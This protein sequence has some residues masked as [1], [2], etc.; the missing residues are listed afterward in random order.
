[1]YAIRSYYDE[2]A[3]DNISCIAKGEP[4]NN[5]PTSM[6]EIE[7]HQINA[8]PNPTKSKCTIEADKQIKAISLVNSCGIEVFKQKINNTS[9]QI[10]ISNTPIGFYTLFIEFEDGF[11]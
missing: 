5:T 1:M 10:D 6:N 7:S 4:N 9:T 2:I 3:I 8:F 11:V